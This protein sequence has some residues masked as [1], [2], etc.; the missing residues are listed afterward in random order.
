MSKIIVIIGV[1]GGQGLSIAKTFLSEPGFKV[2]GTTRNPSSEK[3]KALAAKGVD[4]V[5]AELGDPASLD[6]AFEGAHII[7]GMTDYYETFFKNGKDVA[8]ETEFQYGRNLADAAARI[9]TLEHYYWSTLPATDAVTQGTALVP[10]FEG[11]SKVDRYIKEYLPDLYNKT[12]FFFFTIFTDNFKLYDIFKPVWIAAAQKWIQFYPTDPQ[13]PYTTIGDHKVN[14]GI[15]VRAALRK[16][17]IKPGS[18]IRCYIDVY[19]LESFL[20]L[21]GRASGIS[22]AAGSTKVVQLSPE[23]YISLFGQM[24]EEQASQWR[25]VEYLKA[26]GIENPLGNALINGID[27]LNDE[28]KAKLVSTEESLQ[29]MDWSGY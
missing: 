4:V 16:T 20:A 26:N 23:Q 3:A 11:K 29:R 13:T 14:S 10:H 28:D 6:K 17:E 12:L 7:F 8:M 9:P 18:Y 22:P 2:R 25:F 21:W 19:T 24:G 1:T 27:L 5:R 15:F